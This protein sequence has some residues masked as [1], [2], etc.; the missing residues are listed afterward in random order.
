M[1]CD[2]VLRGA[3]ITAVG[4]QA[5]AVEALGFAGVGVTETNGNPFL[6]A[7]QAAGATSTVRVSTAIALAFPRTPMDVAYTAWDL[8]TLSGGRFALGLGTQVRAHV[9]RR[10]GAVWSRPAARMREYVLAL[11]AIWDAWETGGPLTYEGEIYSHTLMPPNFRPA[12]TAFPRPPVL[13]AAVRARMTEVAGEVADGF[14]GHAF[15]TADVLRDVTLPALERGLERGGRARADVEVTASVFVAASDEDWEANRRRVAFYGSTPGY[16][17]V[18]DH[19]GLGSLFEALHEQSRS[20]GWATMPELIDDDVLAL[21]V[22]RGSSPEE[23]ADGVRAR[24]GE[25]AD[26][27]ALVAEAADPAAVAPIAAALRS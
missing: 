8:Q 12:P 21:F 25:V 7:A 24:V 13:L 2:V 14:L 16:R 1:Q 20:G 26:R 27:V 18:F 4:E 3:A 5:A 6:A 22:V 19:H 17:H 9:E 15:C 11:H 23:I 10:Y